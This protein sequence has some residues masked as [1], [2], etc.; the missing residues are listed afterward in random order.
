ME[1][2]TFVG[3][4]MNFEFGK[5]TFVGGIGVMAFGG[6]ALTPETGKAAFWVIV[7][8]NIFLKFISMPVTS[9]VCVTV[10]KCST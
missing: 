1:E 8:N 7:W 3:G 5:G 10:R 6:E 2:H 4:A 9:T